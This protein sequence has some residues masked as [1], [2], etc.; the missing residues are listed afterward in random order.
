LSPHFDDSQ[1]M[2]GWKSAWVHVPWLD[3]HCLKPLDAV[4]PL[5]PVADPLVPVVDPLVP[6]ELVPLE[7]LED[8]QAMA[9]A[10]VPVAKP[11]SS[12]VRVMDSP[13]SEVKLALLPGAL[14]VRKG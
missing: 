13:W 5:V 7:E 12:M 9:R 8:E 11:I 3:E 6:P 14:A 1:S 4:L 10:T 2:N